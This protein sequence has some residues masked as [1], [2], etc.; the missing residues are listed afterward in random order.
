MQSDFADQSPEKSIIVI[1]EVPRENIQPAAPGEHTAD[2]SERTYSR[3]TRKDTR[4]WLQK[5]TVNRD[6]YSILHRC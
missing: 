5:D 2:G 3:R 6:D 4:Y 1:I